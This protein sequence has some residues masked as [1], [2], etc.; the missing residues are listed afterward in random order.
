MKTLKRPRQ[1]G[2]NSPGKTPTSRKERRLLDANIPLYG[3]KDKGRSWKEIADA[4]YKKTMRHKG[5]IAAA[6]TAGLALYY[7]YNR[8]QKPPSDI[9]DMIKNAAPKPER[10]ASP[11]TKA[12]AEPKAK[13]PAEPEAK[14]PAEPEAKAPAEPEAKAPGP[15]SETHE[16]IMKRLTAET[17][18][19]RRERNDKMRNFIKENPHSEYAK[20]YLRE[21]SELMRTTEPVKKE[22]TLHTTLQTWYH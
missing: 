4:A 14:A 9:A 21:Y 17:E 15:K 22:N 1:R 13:A 12:P 2:G 11:K 18:A 7:L 19:L 3:R 8:S 10:A 5:K 6:A 20:E 16:Q